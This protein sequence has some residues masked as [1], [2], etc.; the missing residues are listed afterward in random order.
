[1]PVVNEAWT[2]PPTVTLMPAGAETIRSPLRPLA[3]TVSVEV[4]TGGVFGFTVSVANWVELPAVAK[5]VS[6]VVL[7]TAPTG[8]GKKGVHI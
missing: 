4:V 6:P 7:V 8:I 1:M 2:E 3:E 5:I